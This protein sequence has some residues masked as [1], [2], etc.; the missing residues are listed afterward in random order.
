MNVTRLIVHSKFHQ[1]VRSATPLFTIIISYGLLGTCVPLKTFLS[2]VPVIAGV[3]LATFGDFYF[4]RWG[5]MLTLLGTFLAALKTVYTNVLQT[6]SQRSQLNSSHPRP[7]SLVEKGY[8]T[9]AMR[10][11][12]TNTK[13][14]LDS[15][16]LLYR[17]SPLALI[18]CI[19]YA[20]FT[21][22]LSDI[23]HNIC[24]WDCPSQN[25][26]ASVGTPRNV[27]GPK[28]IAILGLNGIL[29]FA[30]NYVSLTANGKAGALSMTVAGTTHS[31]RRLRSSTYDAFTR[32]KISANVKQVLTLM[33]AVVMF[34]IKVTPLN[35]LG[36]ILTLLGGAC[37][38]AVEY[39]Q[40]TSSN[41]NQHT[42]RS[43]LWQLHR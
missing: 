22:E 4:T 7:P 35:L 41:A 18:Q 30:L 10:S 27:I 29:A 26:F 16:D 31:L 6:D 24:L 12:S 20:V 13:K 25:F 23:R 2:L 8:S 11:T 38:A 32:C 42:S 40:K 17:M 28:E 33:L 1:V 14:R 21:G 9:E 39:K 34:D 15:L 5:L 36:I 37:Y 43:N 19:L 3:C